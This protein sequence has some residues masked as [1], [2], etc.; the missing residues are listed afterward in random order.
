MVLDLGCGTGT[1]A[2]EMVAMLK[3]F[4]VLI[5]RQ[6]NVECKKKGT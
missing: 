4:M 3:R 1:Q 5:H 6:K 2:L